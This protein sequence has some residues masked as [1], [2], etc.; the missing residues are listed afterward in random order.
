MQEIT[1]DNDN[2]VKVGQTYHYLDITRGVGQDVDDGRYV[3]FIT[4]D[5][6]YAIS[7]VIL[8]IFKKDFD[9]K[10]P[11]VRVLALF[12]NVSKPVEE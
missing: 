2:V 5:E 7:C 3:V 8:D 11:E 4:A 12:E 10:N 9:E 6:R 1:I